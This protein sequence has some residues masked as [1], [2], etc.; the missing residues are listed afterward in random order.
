[1]S[2]TSKIVFA[3]ALMLLGIEASMA[4]TERERL[5]RQKQEIQNRIRETQKILSQTAEKRTNSLGQ[6]RALN[7]QIRSRGSLVNAIKGK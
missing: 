3:I 5:E 2:V 6:L 7:N 1:M 4:Q